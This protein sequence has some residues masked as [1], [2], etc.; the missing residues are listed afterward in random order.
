MDPNDC[1]RMKPSLRSNALVGFQEMAEPVKSRISGEPGA[2][3]GT[4][5]K[6]GSNESTDRA[7]SLR[8]GEDS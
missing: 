1:R 2:G 3:C 8:E 6:G 4:L 7:L 5:A